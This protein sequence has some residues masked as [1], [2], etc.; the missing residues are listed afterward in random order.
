[1]PVINILDDTPYKIWSDGTT[2]YF[3]EKQEDKVHAY[4]SVTNEELS[5]IDSKMERV[6]EFN[7]ELRAIHTAVTEYKSLAK[8]PTDTV[9]IFAELQ[10]TTDQYYRYT[11]FLNRR[12][13]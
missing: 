11:R 10:L 5:D 1:M 8:K 13:I 4:S 2:L 3:I 6:F 7:A 9:K 12:T